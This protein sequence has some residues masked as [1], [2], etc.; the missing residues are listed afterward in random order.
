MLKRVLAL[1]GQTV[2]R[3][4]LTITVDKIEMGVA[5][6]R[7]SRGR[8]LPIWQGCRVVADG[9]VF[10]MNWQ[11]ANSLDGRYFG[12]LPMTAIV[13]KGAASLDQRG[14][15]MM[16]P[17]RQF[18]V[19][20]LFGQNTDHS[21]SGPCFASPSRASAVQ[22]NRRGRR[23]CTSPLSAAIGMVAL[24]ILGSDRV[25]CGDSYITA[26]RAMKRMPSRLR[27]SRTEQAVDPTIPSQL[28]SPRRPNALRVPEHWIR[29]SAA[30]RKRGETTGAIAE[31]G[32]GTDADHAKDLD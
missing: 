24:A 23:T 1:P 11:S 21:S 27:R 32:D 5:R 26:I 17:D 18:R 3:Q 14:V 22:D 7:D 30:S 8:L 10:L 25:R 29:A 15:I 20:L 13:G 16:S 4:G 28:L 19:I 12:V 9:E 6:E 31:G 2:C